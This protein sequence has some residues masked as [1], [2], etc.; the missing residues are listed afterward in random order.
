MAIK[1]R[2]VACDFVIEADDAMRG[3]EVVCPKCETLNVMRSAEDAAR[4][5]RDDQVQL[6]QERRRFLERLARP[7]A[8]GGA[9][10][11]AWSPPDDAARGL[12]VLAGRRLKDVSVYVLALAYLVL[13]LAFVIA[14]L[15]VIGTELPPIWKA[16]GFLAGATTGVVVFVIFKFTSDAVRALA[17]VTDLLRS[18]DVRLERLEEVHS[19][20]PDHLVVAGSASGGASGGDGGAG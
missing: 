14:G 13:V 20:S 19:G 9:V 16:F 18:L 7:A 3:R 2:C 17:D 5:R 4:M 1:N 11:A 15:L 6:D 12:A 10:P 8:P